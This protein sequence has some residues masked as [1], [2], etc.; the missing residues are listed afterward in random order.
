METKRDIQQPIF[1]ATVVNDKASDEEFTNVLK[2][3]APGT[4]IRSAINGVVKAG[5]GALIAIDAIN[6]QSLI[7]GGF[8]LNV[9]FTPQKLIELSKMDGAIILSKDLK[10]ILSAN[11]LLTPNSKTPTHETGTRHKA[12]ERVARQA[13]TLVIAVSERRNEITMYY[14]NIRY[15]LIDS[16]QLLRKA[17]EHVQML[18]KQRDLFDKYIKKLDVLELRNYPSLEAAIQVIQKGFI[19]QKISGDLNKYLVELGKEGVI[20]KTRLKEII[21]DV[22]E[23]TDLV[24]T[25]YTKLDVRKSRAMLEELS[26]DD[27]LDKTAIL[28]ILDYEK[29]ILSG[30]IKGWRILSKTTLPLQDIA[31][32]V[33]EAGSL[34]KAIYS[35]RDFHIGIVGEENAK[36]FKEEID[37]IKLNA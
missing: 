16:S 5:K 22:D 32:I 10:R 26:Y 17:S 20:L 35:N 33:K 31:A 11:V 13:G 27:L 8:R 6:L 25:D 34:G 36:V 9:K 24:I 18:E 4:N 30:P 7:D 37:N 28:K 23:E 3:L 12:A 15:P 21:T 29:P 19:I 2:M 14:K 1:G